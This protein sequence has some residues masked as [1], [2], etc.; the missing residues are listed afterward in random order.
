MVRLDSVRAKHADFRLGILGHQVVVVSVI[1]F[2]LVQLI[3]VFVVVL[4]ALL[5]LS[6]H[7]LVDLLG[8]LC[9]FLS[10][11]IMLGLG[12][13]ENFIQFLRLSVEQRINLLVGLLLLLFFFNLLLAPVLLL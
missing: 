1:D 2:S 3:T 11:L 4:V 7:H 6:C 8:V 13:A 12:L 10:S 9:I 5:L